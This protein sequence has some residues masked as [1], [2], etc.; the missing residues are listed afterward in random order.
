MEL[1]LTGDMLPAP[2]AAELGL[3][4]RLVAEGAAL[5]SALELA[6]RIAENAPLAVRGA[7]RVVV[8]S[9]DWPME[10]AFER[11]LPIYEPIR[12]S[13]DAREGARAFTE[14]RP[15]EWRGR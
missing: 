8:E 11:Q 1:I 15:P 9:R 12:N 3:V 6:E 10:E 4:N 2:R 13:E 14:K 7:K 5:E